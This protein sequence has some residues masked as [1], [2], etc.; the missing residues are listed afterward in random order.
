MK[1]ILFLLSVCYLMIEFSFNVVLVDL[2]SDD[3]IHSFGN[4]DI[5]GRCISAIGLTLIALRAIV[6]V[7]TKT[8]IK[9]LL[10]IV[11]LPSVAYGTYIAQEKV[12]DYLSKNNTNGGKKRSSLHLCF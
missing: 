6:L 12:V 7:K 5:I 11:I 10:S 8:I 9:L 4:I 2:L 3:S 1:V